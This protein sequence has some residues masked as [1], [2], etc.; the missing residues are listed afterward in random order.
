MKAQ[1]NVKELTLKINGYM[2]KFDKIKEDMSENG[3]KFED[4]Q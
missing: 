1:E 3:K 2:E 4:Y